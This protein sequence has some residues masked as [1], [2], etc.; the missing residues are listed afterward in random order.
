V[1][2]GR[3][4]VPVALRQVGLTTVVAAIVAVGWQAAHRSTTS[5]APIVGSNVVAPDF[6]LERI[7]AHGVIRRR[8]YGGKVMVVNFWASWCGPCKDEAP[9]LE[10]AWRRWQSRGLEVVGIATRDS[11]G[12]AQAFARSHGLTYALADDPAGAIADSYRVNSLPQTF[13]VSPSG[14][15]LARLV[16]AYDGAT[17]DRQLRRAFGE[18]SS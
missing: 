17:L 3:T 11:P 9:I 14:R 5:A 18:S 10:G 16:G 4:R 2:R 12:S 6:R 13:V 1:S 8:D 7:D 15:V